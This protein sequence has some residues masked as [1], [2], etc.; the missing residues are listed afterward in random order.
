MAGLDLQRRAERASTPATLDPHPNCERVGRR[1]LLAERERGAPADGVRDHRRHLAGRRHQLRRPQPEPSCTPAA[2][3]RLHRPEHAVRRRRRPTGRSSRRWP[4]PRATR[5]ARAS[6]SSTATAASTWSRPRSRA[7]AG[8]IPPEAE[9]TSPKWYAQV[10]PTPADG[11]DRAA[12]STRAATS[13]SCTRARRAGLRAQQRPH[14]RHAARR[15]PAGV[16]VLVQRLAHTSPFDGTLAQLNIA[17]SQGALPGDDLQL[18]RAASRRPAP[19][20]FNNRPNQRAVRLH[21]QGRRHRRSPAAWSDRRGPA[22]L[23]PA[24]RPGH[25][26]GLPEDAAERRRVLAGARRPRRRQPNELVFGTSD[27]VVH[28]DAPRRQR[29][30]GLAGPQRPAAAPHRRPRLH[31]RRGRRTTSHGAILASVAVGRPRPRRH[32]RGGRRRHGGQALRLER[33]RH[34]ALQARGRTSTTPASRC[35]RS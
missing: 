20:N 27:G 18:Q 12:R 26:A 8:T 17:D 5:R 33:R 15:L 9:I 23:L 2:D 13:Y 22:Q 30:A 16:V 19:P 1:P 3:A 7:A 6:T 14:E 31:Q 29:A 34:A 32:A 25:A 10:D 4:R 11:R 35:S 28:A 21:G 24:P